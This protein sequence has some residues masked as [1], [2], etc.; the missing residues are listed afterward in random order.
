[1]SKTIQN[2]DIAEAIVASELLKEGFQ[3][4]SP[5]SHNT[6][7]DMIVLVSDTM[8]PIKIQVKKVFLKKEGKSKMARYIE[9]RKRTDG[10]PRKYNVNDF[11][12]CIAC[13][14]TTN[15]CWII[16]IFDFLQVGSAMSV[17]SV[18]AKKYYK[19]WYILKGKEEFVVIDFRS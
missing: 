1:M 11:D 2:G 12:Y 10:N 16:P 7:C 17:D 13:D 8:E 19:S 18:K 5:F 9:T 3:V 14:I 6:T 15:E 4:F